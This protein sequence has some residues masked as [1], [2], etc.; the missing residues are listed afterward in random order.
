M[1]IPAFQLNKCDKWEN[2]TISFFVLADFLSVYD[3]I[4][5][6]FK[7]KESKKLE[8]ISFKKIYTQSGRQ[9]KIDGEPLWSVVCKITTDMKK[10]S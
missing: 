1:T 5:V 8:I 6:P 9:S 10:T 4:L 2:G 7:N 3:K